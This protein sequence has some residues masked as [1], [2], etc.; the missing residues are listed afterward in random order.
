MLYAISSRRY[1]K[2]VIG[3]F[4]AVICLADRFRSEVY[5]RNADWIVDSL[6]AGI[7]VCSSVAG[8]YVWK[9]VCDAWRKRGREH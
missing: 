5:W 2:V 8:H 7:L 9:A 4:I 1:S 6:L 3:F